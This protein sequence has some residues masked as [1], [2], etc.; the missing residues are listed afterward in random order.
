[1]EVFHAVPFSS[2]VRTGSSDAVTIPLDDALAQG[3]HLSAVTQDWSDRLARQGFP[4]DI[5]VIRRGGAPE[6]ILETLNHGTYDLV[7]VGSQSGPGHFLGSVANAVVRFA[8]QSVLVV[9]TRTE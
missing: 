3:S 1:L 7:V 6:A 2:A 4:R 8:G 9:R 5:I